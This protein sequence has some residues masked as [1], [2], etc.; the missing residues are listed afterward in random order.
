MTHAA[1]I[2][3]LRS[4]GGRKHWPTS[5]VIARRDSAARGTPR[6]C[7][8]RGVRLLQQARQLFETVDDV[9]RRLAKFIE[10]IACAVDPAD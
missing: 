10:R 4:G 1:K 2:F 8:S 7:G 9:I 3:L 5:S 6:G